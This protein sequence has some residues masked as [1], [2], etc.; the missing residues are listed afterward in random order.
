M[1]VSAYLV[2]ANNVIILVILLLDVLWGTLL[3]NKTLKTMNKNATEK[4][5][6]LFCKAPSSDNIYSMFHNTF[7][8]VLMSRACKND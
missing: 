6:D 4:Y 5:S 8:E 3:L 2:F 1:S 7:L